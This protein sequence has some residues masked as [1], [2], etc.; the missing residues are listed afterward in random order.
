MNWFLIFVISYLITGFIKI[1][2]EY[3]TLKDIW[4]NFDKHLSKNLSSLEISQMKGSSFKDQR[5]I[6]FIVAVFAI[7]LFWP[8]ITSE[9]D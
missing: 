8:F 7:W 5:L 3:F 9:I 1:F 6:N 4:I 2:F